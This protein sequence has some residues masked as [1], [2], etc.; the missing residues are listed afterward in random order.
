MA[1]SFKIECSWHWWLTTVILASQEARSGGSQFEASMGNSE[2]LSGKKK[3]TKKS[4]WSGSWCRPWVQTPVP[5]KKR[6]K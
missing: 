4:W 2:T 6:V 1:H 3:I 5:Q